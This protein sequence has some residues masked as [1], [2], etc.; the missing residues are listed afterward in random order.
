MTRVWNYALSRGDVVG[1]LATVP[2][3]IVDPLT[4]EFV[5]GGYKLKETMRKVFK[6]EDFVKF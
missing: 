6:A 2:K 1:D 5:A 4:Q 3:V